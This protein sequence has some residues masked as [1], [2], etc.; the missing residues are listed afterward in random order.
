MNRLVT[1][2]WS[3]KPEE[4]GFS[5]TIVTGEEP[6]LV[7]GRYNEHYWFD[8]EGIKIDVGEEPKEPQ[9]TFTIR[10]RVALTWPGPGEKGAPT[11][12]NEG[13]V[14]WE[15]YPAAETYLVRILELVREENSTSSHEVAI[16]PVT[17]DTRFP[18]AR[19]QALPSESGEKEYQASVLAFAQDGQFLSETAQPFQGHTF[20]LTDNKQFVRESERIP[21]SN[22][23][24]SEELEQM[25]DNNQRIDAVAVLL[26]NELPNEAE[27]LLGKVRGK[28]DPGKKAAVTGYLMA[29][30]GRCAEANRLFAQAQSEG[31]H[32]CVPQHYRAGCG[33]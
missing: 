5:F 14:A 15:P 18:L 22:R 13:V 6:K 31:G 20:T 1:R 19:L 10:K 32:T 2:E 28:T 12:V 33:K 30:R 4:D 7:G 23:F 9:L 3:D 24:S 26:K 16:H 11:T 21:G 25:R 29:V 8:R 17:G 27:R